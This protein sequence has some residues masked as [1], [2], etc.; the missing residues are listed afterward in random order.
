VNANRAAR[1]AENAADSRPVRILGRIGI[2]AHAVVYLLIAYLAMRIAFGGGGGKSTDK[3]GALQ[4]LAEQPGGKIALWIVALG[5]L[6]FVIWQ[7]AE[8]AFGY[9]YVRDKKK[10]TLKRVASAG[11]GIVFGAIG[12][13]AAKMAT[14]SSAGGRAKNETFTAKVLALPAGQVL[15]ALAGLAVIAVAAFVVYRGVTKRFTEDLDLA[16][17]SPSERKAAIR[18]GQVGYPALGAAYVLVGLLIVV[19]AVQYD[20]NKATGLDVALKTLAGQPYGQ[21]MLT[22][23]AAGLAAYGLYG[24]LDARFRRS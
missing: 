13:T 2:A 3:N 7:L 9:R 10:R 20:P 14:G 6:A 15:V 22:V 4:T 11:E 12:V 16:G 8:A 17:A 18:L 24:L 21:I 1:T 5:L 23:I 19:A